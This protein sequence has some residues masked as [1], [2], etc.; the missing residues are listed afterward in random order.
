MSLKRRDFIKLSAGSA[1]ASTAMVSGIAP[2][3]SLSTANMRVFEK[4]EKMTGDVVPI[5]LEERQ[6]RIAKA[7]QLMS[8]NNIHALLL[9]SGTSLVYFTGIHWWPSER[10]MVAIIPAK[11]EVKYVGPAFEADRLR[12]LIK[13]GNEVRTW[14]ED[15]SPYKVIAGVLKDYGISTG[16]VGI[17][18]R[19]RFFVYDGV[20]KEAP[21]INF[22]SGD[23][24][25]IPCRMIKSPAEIALLQK[26]NDIT[27]AAIKI[28]SEELKEG[29]SN[30]QISS[31]I[32]EA[33]RKLGGA[34]DGALVNIGISSALPHGSIKPQHIKNGDIVL[35]DCGCTVE[36]YCSDITRTIVFGAKPT[37][38]QRE[39]WGL[40]KRAQD[41]GFAAA[42]IGQ[43]CENVDIAARKVLI[44]AGYGPGYKLPGCPHR[45]GHGIGMD[46]HEWG[47]M[48]LGNKQPLQAGMCFSIEPTIVFPGEFGIRLEDCAHI[49]EDGPKWFSKTSGSVDHPFA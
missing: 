12:E 9:D 46:G 38:R 11:G 40:E 28:V 1:A 24:V 21:G 18:E 33:Q 26:A 10:T 39:I 15:E 35:M 49:T 22:V 45:T 17:E 23:P 6:S 8:E 37:K 47:N 42:Q 30:A 3:A 44:D 20:R 7:Q 43:P 27:L 41:A 34:A 4:L 14:E 13:I 25:T 19:L 48:V 31:M 32:G 29:M 5:S 16:N 2:F 36:G